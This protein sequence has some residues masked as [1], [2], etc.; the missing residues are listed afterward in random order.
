M[1]AL[2]AAT[3]MVLS[4]GRVMVLPLRVFTED[5]HLTHVA[6]SDAEWCAAHEGVLIIMIDHA[7]SMAL[8]LQEALDY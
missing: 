7:H 5:L 1:A 4:T 3:V 2:T 6:E 8:W